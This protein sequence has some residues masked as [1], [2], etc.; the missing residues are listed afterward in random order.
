MKKSFL[1]NLIIVLGLNLS[2][3][4]FFIFA[5][6]RQVQN[7]VGTQEYG[8]YF[9]LLSFSFLFN[10]ILDLGITSFNNRNIAQNTHLL[11]KHF[12]RMIVLKLTLAVIYL[13][14]CTIVGL[15][16]GYDMR[17]MKLLLI[18]CFMQF[19][20]SFIA[21]LRSN[22]SGMHLFK[23]DSMIS[24]MDRMIAIAIC[25]PFLWFHFFAKPIDIMDYVYIQLGAYG[26]TATIAFLIVVRK[27]G[28]ISF[29]WNRTF[30][31]MILKQSF[32]FALLAMIMSFYNRVDG[33]LLERLVHDNGAQDGIYA[34]AFRLLDATNM[35]AVLAAGLLLPIFARMLKFNESVE[36]MVKVAYTLLFAAAV[37]IAGSCYFYSGDIMKMLYKNDVQET[38]IIFSILMCCFMGSATQYVFG[39]LLTANG[40]LKYMNIIAAS[41]MFLN[42]VFNFIMIPRYHAIGAA[43]VSLATQLFVPAVQIMVIQRV[44]KFKSLGKLF[45]TLGIFAIGVIIIGYFSHRLPL[46]WRVS[47]VL[48]AGASGILAF[49]VGLLNVKGLL[50]VLKKG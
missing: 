10:V 12:S 36:S 20:I 16:S 48:M 6:D 7:I 49:A 46:D 38:S 47:F 2:I 3:K 24:A 5:V 28:F 35:I 40:N 44:F 29:E 33:F 34:Q 32:P 21:Y 27:A 19:L 13:T 11:S 22:I 43:C 14:V 18:L 26:L 9:G 37:V 17:R 45:L 41:G 4:P 50:S 15:A 31:L 42:I 23:T 30:S 1:T 25:A 8:V 39:T